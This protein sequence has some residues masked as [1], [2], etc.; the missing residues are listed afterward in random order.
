MKKKK[1][2]KFKEDASKAQMIVNPFRQLGF[3]IQV[4]AEVGYIPN[5][6]I[7]WAEQSIS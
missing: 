4:F 1:K 7:T 2:E 6:A 3:H 5:E